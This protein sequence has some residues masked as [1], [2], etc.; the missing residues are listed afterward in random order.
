MWWDGFTQSAVGLQ[1]CSAAQALLGP[2]LSTPRHRCCP[3]RALMLAP[4][5]QVTQYLLDQSGVMDEEALYGASLRME[6]KLP[7]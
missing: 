2:F 1:H 7:S 3:T 4:V 5:L 6:P